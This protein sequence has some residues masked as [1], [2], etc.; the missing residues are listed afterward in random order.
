MIRGLVIA[1]LVLAAWFAP[2]A[3]AADPMAVTACPSLRMPPVSVPHLRAALRANQPLLIVA[4]GSSSTQ[5]YMASDPAHTYP[6]VLQD[7]LSASLPQ[8][9]VAVINRGIGGQ[10]AAE[11]VTRIDTDVI[12]LRPQ[13]VIWQ[14]GAN[15]ALRG[16]D[17]EVFRTLVRNGV[18]RMRDAG[19]DVILMD[20]QR[21]PR[22]LA[23]PSH[24]L[25]DQSLADVAVQ[26]GASLFQRSALMD[27]W[28]NAG[29]PYKTF[30]SADGLHHNDLGYHCVAR[31]LASSI[32]AGLGPAQTAAQL[33]LLQRGG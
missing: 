4:L 20:N 8:A 30:I 13:T 2:A 22:I 18:K 25:I 29:L 14:V 15:G 7:T 12:A 6:A 23:A 1:A 10:D 26:T 16:T 5:S 32:V 24:V 33:S 17:P 9:H 3:R 31:A 19:M 11:E 28:R 27:G 21:A